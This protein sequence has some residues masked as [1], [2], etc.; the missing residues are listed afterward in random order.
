M[1]PEQEVRCAV[2]LPNVGPTGDPRL[3]VALATG[4][5]AAGW[6]GFFVWD[7][8]LYRDPAWP[9]AD[10]V[11]AVSA[12][13]AAT[14]RIRLGVLVTA[15]AR[16]RPHKVARE[17][18]TLDVLSGGRVVFGAGLGSM[19]E[20]YAAFGEDPD[21][22]VRAGKLD[23]GLEVLAGLW[24]G[25]PFS[26]AGRHHR[27]D[28]VAMRPPP[29]QRPR[30]PVWVGGRWPARA[31]FRRAAR[32]DGVVPTHAAYGKGETM[33]PAELAAVVAYVT[34][35]R[36]EG[37]T[38][39]DVVLEGRTDGHDPAADAAVVRP[40][41]AVG[42]TWWVEALG[43]WRGDVDALRRRVAQGPPSVEGP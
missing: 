13:A 10:P 12:A 22:K 36:A 29:L 4:A 9:V 24:S 17:V 40:Y 30:V 33:P 6:D 18:A 3:L 34:R 7:H 19:P 20:E 42:L 5:E 41:A 27:V 25:E 23:E 28:G 26:F 2:G 39:F 14:G 1:G 31:P 16:R 35:H 38:P 15:L 37:A 43:W 11:V 8:V 32:W 21:P